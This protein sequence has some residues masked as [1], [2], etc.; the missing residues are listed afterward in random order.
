MGWGSVFVW[1]AG[2]PVAL[3]LPLW[4]PETLFQQSPFF[5]ADGIAWAF[6]LSLTTLCLAVII[7]AVRAANFPSP[8]SWIGVLLLTALVF[9]Q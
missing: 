9:W 6:A 8:L 5:I 1:Q 4:K 3:Q 7:T 2:L